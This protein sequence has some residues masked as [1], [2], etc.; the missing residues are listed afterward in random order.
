MLV[1]AAL[2]FILMRTFFLATIRAYQRY[3]SPYKGFSCAYRVHT[4]RSSCSALGYRAIRIHGVLA[5][6]VILR[7][8]M[9]LC[10]VAHRRYSVTR[11]KL[12]AKQGGYCDIGCDGADCGSGCDGCHFPHIEG[13]SNVCNCL[14]YCDVGSCDWPERKRRRQDE[15][16]Y[17]HI[18]PK[19]RL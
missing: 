7:E 1:S 13:L 9:F 5:G 4:G 8:R 16:K 10:G 11:P 19:S 15:E 12:Y 17:V 14:S 6:F 2:D 18:P 3:L